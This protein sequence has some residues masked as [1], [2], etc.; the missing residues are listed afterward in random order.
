MAAPTF[1]PTRASRW[2]RVR[3][4][5]LLGILVL[6]V[7]YT[8]A[9][10][11]ARRSL[12]AELARLEPK[13]G[14]LRNRTLVAPSVP[15]AENRARL[16]SA[17]ASLAIPASSALQTAIGKLESNSDTDK[18]PA[19]LRAFVEQNH[20]ALV[21]AKM[22]VT[23]PKTSW[24]VD[25]GGGGN[26]PPLLELRNLSNLLYLNA[27]VE[28]D[29]H[30]PDEAARMLATA[31]ASASSLNNEPQLIAQ[32]V[33]MA[34]AD[35]QFAGIQRVLAQSDPSKSALEDL[36]RWLEQGRSDPSRTGLEA[37]FAYLSTTLSRLEAGRYDGS[38]NHGLPAS[39]LL[40]RIGRPLVRLAHARY[41]RTMDRL[42]AYQGGP[43]PRPEWEPP[44]ASR[45]SPLDTFVNLSL[46]GLART[47]QTAD[48]YMS[49]L[50]ACEISVAL[51]RYKLD[52]G[53][54]PDDLA[55]LTP[56]YLDKLPINPYTG[57][58]PV[59]ARDGS[60]FSLK[61]PRDK[62]YPPTQRPL[63]NWTIAK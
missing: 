7:G 30:R 6:L 47:I 57:Q 13:Y 40:L 51:R 50:G 5:V 32:L 27:M 17:A 44:P 36:A 63:Q 43:R 25:Y 55:A 2:R 15:A 49:M 4:F 16:V 46:P 12:E 20:D 23:R 33:R 48:D 58:V 19:D 41:L 29:A 60:G 9:D 56:A 31:L 1:T 59:Y 37:E 61:A 42:L 35:R 21:L 10:L 52:H 8:A 11:Y 53:S 24:D 14:N 34:M 3:L 38:L 45:W 54:Y 26:T 39:P 22:I 62:R 18:V 28:L